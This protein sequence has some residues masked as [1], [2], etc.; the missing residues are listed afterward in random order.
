MAG[1]RSSRWMPL[2]DHLVQTTPPHALN[3]C[4]KQAQRGEE[5]RPESQSNVRNIATCW[6]GGQSPVRPHTPKPECSAPHPSVPTALLVFSP[7]V[8]MHTKKELWVLFEIFREDFLSLF[9]KKFPPDPSHFGQSLGISKAENLWPFSFFVQT[10]AR[11]QAAYVREL[12]PICLPNLSLVGAAA[13]CLPFSLQNIPIPTLKAY[14][15]ALKDNSYVK[16]FSIVG[17]RSN[18]PV[19]YVCTF[20]FCC[21]EGEGHRNTRG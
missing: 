2:R 18:D 8:S 11:N 3:L 10:L 1:Q 5:T 9:T 17:T 16:K 21:I 19:A 7:P 12:P 20:L 4:H 6:G 15:E 14:A 13:H